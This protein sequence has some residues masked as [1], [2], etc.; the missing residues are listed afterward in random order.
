[1]STGTPALRAI[2]GGSIAGCWPHAPTPLLRGVMSPPLAL[3]RERAAVISR[4]GRRALAANGRAG[5]RRKK[6]ELT[7]E[8]VWQGS[9]V[10]IR[11]SARLRQHNRGQSQ[12]DPGHWH[13]C[14][15]TLRKSSA[16]P[17]PTAAI[18]AC[19]RPIE[20]YLDLPSSPPQ[21]TTPSSFIMP[22]PSR[23]SSHPR[24]YHLPAS[25]GGK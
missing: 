25:R 20:F 18:M 24:R 5:E 7:L 1:V 19:G 17:Y 22:R 8:H 12:S 15:L 14:G 6:S 9:G 23:P 16:L 10:E 11:P 4:A 3:R 2:V 21:A 13:Q